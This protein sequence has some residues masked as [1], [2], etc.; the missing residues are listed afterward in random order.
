MQKYF[1]IFRLAAIHAIKNYKVLIGLSLF[2]IACLIIFANLWEV[3]VVKTGV[4]Q[5]PPSHLVWYIAFNQWILISIPEISDEIELDFRTGRLAY[6]LPRPI[7]YLGATFAESLGILCVNFVV[8]G[9]VTF[10]FTWTQVTSFPFS[11]WGIVISIAL[12]FLSCCIGIIL[13]MLV[14][15]SAFWFHD[16]API[17]FVSEKLLFMLGGLILP[18]SLYPQWLQTIAYFTPFPI[19]L[20]ERSALA[21]NFNMQNVQWLFTFSAFWLIL[22]IGLLLFVYRRGLRILNMEGG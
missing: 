14:G 3:A 4:T 20:G 21:L 1:F 12:G 10:A 11:F 15:L 9:I 19:I 5:Y 22:G 13:K 17:D 16:V 18:L 6:L 7:S 8:L 2:L